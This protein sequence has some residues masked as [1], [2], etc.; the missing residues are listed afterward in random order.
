[1]ATSVFVGTYATNRLQQKLPC[2][3]QVLVGSYCGTRFPFGGWRCGLQFYSCC[4]PVVPTIAE[5]SAVMC[6][7]QSTGST[8]TSWKF[9]QTLTK[10]L[11]WRLG[12]PFH[13][14][15]AQVRHQ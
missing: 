6:S 3:G 13:S 1:M 9:Q 15:L 10:P 11:Q 2:L 4:W 5:A 12:T 7:S 8:Q 14:L